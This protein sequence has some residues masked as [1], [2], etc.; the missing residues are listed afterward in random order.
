MFINIDELAFF[1]NPKIHLNT[2]GG[3]NQITKYILISYPFFL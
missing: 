1:F 3:L 2:Y